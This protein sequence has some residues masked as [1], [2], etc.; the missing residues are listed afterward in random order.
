MG[1]WVRGGERAKKGGRLMH[2]KQNGLSR[3]D[4]GG[5]CLAGRPGGRAGGAMHYDPASSRQ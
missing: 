2:C 5:A 3:V 4:M 1:D